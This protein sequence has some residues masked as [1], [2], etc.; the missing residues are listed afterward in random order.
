MMG[1]YLDV[2]NEII[3][4]QKI[5]ISQIELFERLYRKD[6]SAETKE[7]LE[8][9]YQER[10]EYGEKAEFYRKI[11]NRTQTDQPSITWR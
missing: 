4:L 3:D 8:L 2:C 5:T 1:I 11:H 7:T 9:L 6:K 10:D